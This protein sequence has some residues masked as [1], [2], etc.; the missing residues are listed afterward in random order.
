MLASVEASD[1]GSAAEAASAGAEA[2]EGLV[3]G[4]SA[5][6][7]GADIGGEPFGMLVAFGTSCR[8]GGTVSCGACAVGDCDGLGVSAESAAERSEDPAR[9]GGPAAAIVEAVGPGAGSE[10]RPPGRP[11]PAV[12]AAAPVEPGLEAPASGE[13]A[14]AARPEPWLGADAEEAGPELEVAVTSGAMGVERGVTRTRA[15]VPM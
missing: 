5:P 8:D 13:V 14:G 1:C 12:A 2:T 7:G 4:G 6:D 9:S 10:A 3:S 15:G 11:G